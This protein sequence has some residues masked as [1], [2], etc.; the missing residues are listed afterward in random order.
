L[1][2]RDHRLVDDLADSP[3]SSRKIAVVAGRVPH[4]RAVESLAFKRSLWLSDHLAYSTGFNQGMG[5]ADVRNRKDAVIDKRLYLSGFNECCDV[6][7]D[8]SVMCTAFIWF[9]KTDENRPKSGDK[10]LY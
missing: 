8:L 4:D 5:G 1:L 2:V 9:Q 3:A 10:T 7:E 6:S